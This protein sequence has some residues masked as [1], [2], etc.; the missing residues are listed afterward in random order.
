MH[1]HRHSQDN[2]GTS[3]HM[4]A[5]TLESITWSMLG[6]VGSPNFE[7]QFATDSCTRLTKG[8]SYGAGQAS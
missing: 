7:G 6:K 2:H 3:S 8:L 5:Q 1:A 4:V